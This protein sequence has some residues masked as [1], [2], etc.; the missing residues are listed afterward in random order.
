[1]AL[2]NL[3]RRLVPRSLK[4]AARKEITD[5]FE[6]PSME[7]SLG[8]MRRLGFRPAGVVD[9][10]AYKGEWTE[11]A[12]KIFPEA[13]CLML[14]AQESQKHFLDE[15]KSRNGSAVNY[16]IAVLGPEARDEVV[17]HHY[18]VAP[19]GASMLVAQAGAASRPVKRKME[20]LDSILAQEKFC[21]PELIKI[22]VQGYELEVLKGAMQAL[23]IA[24][25]IAMEVSLLELY[26]GNPLIHEVIPFMH[27]RGFQCYDIPTL[28][29]R[30]SDRTLW[31]VDI[32]FVKSSSPLVKDK[33]GLIP[34][35]STVSSQR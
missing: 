16:R 33:T 9:I 27:D 20:T 24:Q 21:R 29:R 26:E 25:A 2:T 4:E 34:D 10:G 35:G 19:T 30:P 32:I 31:Q 3:L 28:M 15:V 5:R 18:D 13:A 17:F 11:M 1:M 7:W 12:R 8:N 6:V 23:A 14:E 22:D